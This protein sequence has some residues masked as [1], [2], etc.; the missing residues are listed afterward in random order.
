MLS[1]QIPVMLKL[2]WHFGRIML[3]PQAGVYLNFGLGDVTDEDGENGAEYESPLLG[4]VFG[5][6]AGF[7]IGKG[8][9][10][11][12]IRYAMDMGDTKIDK[13]PKWNRSATMFNVGYQRYFEF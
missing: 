4:L 13:G 1:L 5:G 11:L 7:R 9:L 2:D 8:Y 6:A 12:D 10:F 3:Q